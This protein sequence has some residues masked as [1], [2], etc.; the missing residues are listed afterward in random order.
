MRKKDIAPRPPASI[1][2]NDKKTWAWVVFQYKIRGDSVAQLAYRHGYPR[3]TVYQAARIRY[4]KMEWL[5]AKGL[6]LTPEIIWPHRYT[7]DG[8]PIGVLRQP[9]Q[10]ARH[11]AARQQLARA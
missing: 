11:H 4:P 2:G 3:Q 5:I 1:L 7:S 10:A 8:L 6:G 9:K